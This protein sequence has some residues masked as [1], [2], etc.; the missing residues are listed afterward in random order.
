[1]PWQKGLREARRRIRAAFGGWI[2]AQLKMMGIVFLLLTAGLWILKVEYALL[3]GGIISL[4][5]A[6]P[7]LGTGT[8]LIPWALISFLQDHA[9]LGFGLLTLYGVSALIRMVLEPRLV[10]RHLGLHPLLTLMAF[11][12]GCRLFGLPGMIGF[13]LLA[14]IC[15]QLLDGGRKAEP[16]V[17][18]GG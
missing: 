18:G 2:K 6:L 9:P 11:Y 1:V 17:R 12:A 16:A 3:F 10:G 14:L 4:L 13:P 7:V 8:V 15:R 5:D